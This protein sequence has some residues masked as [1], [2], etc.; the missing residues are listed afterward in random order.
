MTQ[1]NLSMK[2][3]QNH[4]HREKTGGCWGEGVGRKMELEVGVS[5]CKLLYIGWINNKFLPYSTENYTQC[6]V[7]NHNG[8]EYLQKNAYICIY[9]VYIG[10]PWWLRC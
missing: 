5:R 4:R 9:I 2:E 10:L 6:P 1:M 8:K 3:K 7:I